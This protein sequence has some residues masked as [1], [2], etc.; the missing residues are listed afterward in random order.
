MMSVDGTSRSR[1]ESHFCAKIH[2]RRRGPL[3]GELE[4]LAELQV[5]VAVSKTE[6]GAREDMAQR[7]FLTDAV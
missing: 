7:R 3:D 6:F 2:T 5:Q 4:K 1:W